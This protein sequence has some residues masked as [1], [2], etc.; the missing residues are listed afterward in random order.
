MKKTLAKIIDIVYNVV[1]I[2]EVIILYMPKKGKNLQGVALER[3][4]D[5]LLSLRSTEEVYNVSSI[6]KYHQQ[7]ID[8]LWTYRHNDQHFKRTLKI[9]GHHL[10]D[11]ENFFFES[12]GYTFPIHLGYVMYSAADYYGF[13][14]HAER[15][16]YL[17]PAKEVRYFLI[18]H[19][20]EYEIE[21]RTLFDMNERWL[22]SG[23]SIPKEKV[24]NALSHFHLL[25]LPANQYQMIHRH[26]T[27]KKKMNEKK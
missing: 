23:R 5:V 21:E 9:N 27:F 10:H 6:E 15:R 7:A 14:Y 24:L 11:D 13:Y 1:E 18:K 3:V 22:I 2:K 17:L 4:M 26:E 8:F 25:D 16:L 19:M 20:H 12:G